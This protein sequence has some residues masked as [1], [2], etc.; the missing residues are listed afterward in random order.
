MADA[1]IFDTNRCTGC[2]AC[3]LAC[4]IENDLEPEASWRRI[5]TYNPDRHPAAPVFHLSLACNHCENP[6]CMHACPALAYSVDPGTG[7]VLLDPDKCIGCRYCSWACPY[8]AP[9]YY[10]PEGVMGKCTFCV[11]RLKAG[12]KPACAALCPTGALDYGDVPESELGGNSVVFPDIDLGPRLKVVPLRPERRKPEMVATTETDL[13]G[14]SPPSR[15]TLASEW[16]LALFTLIA[17]TLVGLVAG[18]V[19]GRLNLGAGSFVGLAGLGF[20]LA[21][22]HLGRP[23]R[24]VRA[25]LNLRRSWLS[26]EIVLLGL[27]AGLTTVYLLLEPHTEAL[28]VAVVALGLTTLY[29]TDRVYSVVA[30]AGRPFLHSAGVLWTGLLL[31]G[32]LAELLWLAYLVFVLKLGLYV[33]RRARGVVAGLPPRAHLAIP[34]ILVGIFL[35]S[36]LLII[37]PEIAPAWP[38]AF[39]LLGELIDRCEYYDDLETESPARRMALDLQASLATRS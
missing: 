17:S 5:E 37:R 4:V 31:T 23:L 26:R 24:A 36:A 15:I 3:R 9:V 16:S 1:F 39:V 28:G 32:I 33:G 14:A 11:H 7:A 38:V 2:H 27:F 10:D 13:A 35:P 29:A 19:S 12:R 30:G 20:V 8:D 34:R 21:T 22:A 6:A 25:V 18:A